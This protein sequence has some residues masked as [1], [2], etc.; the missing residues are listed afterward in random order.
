MDNKFE[1]LSQLF[2]VG[3]RINL[4]TEMACWI[5]ISGHVNLMKI[6]VAKSKEHFNNKLTTHE[7]WYSKEYMEDK[8]YKEFMEGARIALNDLN[9][10]LSS[11]WTKIYKAYCNLLDM[12]CSQVFTSEE[13]AKKWVR[14]MERKYKKVDAIVGYSEDLVNAG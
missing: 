10:I 4:E 1:I 2:E 6:S 14:K 7:F 5:D 8:G 3:M 12:S 13:A 11:D 9:S